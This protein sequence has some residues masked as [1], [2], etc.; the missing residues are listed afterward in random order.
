MIDIVTKECDR[1]KTEEKDRKGRMWIT[2]KDCTE[3]P[4]T[5]V[6]PCNIRSEQKTEK[7]MMTCIR[8]FAA[9]EWNW[10]QFLFHSLSLANWIFLRFEMHVHHVSIEQNTMVKSFWYI[11]F[12]CTEKKMKILKNKNEERF[13][14]KLCTEIFLHRLDDAYWRLRVWFHSKQKYIHVFIDLYSFVFHINNE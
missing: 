12:I 8:S 2:W 10:F 5:R 9:V 13:W 1:K 11:Q 4:E 7:K 14:K 6:G 3:K